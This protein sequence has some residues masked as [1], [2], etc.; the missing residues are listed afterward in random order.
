MFGFISEKAKALSGAAGEKIAVAKDA[1]LDRAGEGANAAAGYLEQHWP[2]IERVLVDGLLTVA[3]DRIRDDDVFLRAVQSS[4]EL[5]PT[6]VRLL[7]PRAAFEQHSLRHRDSIVKKIEM[8]RAE[9]LALNSPAS[10]PR[11]V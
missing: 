5:L 6:P 11:D 10:E 2:K 4:F 7:L 1:V 9:R 3:H 8:K